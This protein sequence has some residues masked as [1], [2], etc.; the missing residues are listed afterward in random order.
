MVHFPAE[1]RAVSA[2]MV[3]LA[4]GLVAAVVP[5]FAGFAWPLVLLALPLPLLARWLL[6]ARRSTT[7]ALRVPYGPR[8]QA[9]SRGAR[10]RAATIFIGC[11]CWPGCCCASPPHGR[12]RSAM[13]CNHRSRGGN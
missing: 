8:L 3:E 10:V 4:N 1:G 2:G 5:G 9:V 11:S 13:Q 12:R 7:A 6:P